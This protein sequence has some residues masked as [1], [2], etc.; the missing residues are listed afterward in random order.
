[1]AKLT[2]ILKKNQLETLETLKDTLL[3]N[4]YKIAGKLYN[5]LKTHCILNNIQMKLDPKGRIKKVLIT[6]K[7]E[8]VLAK[9]IIINNKL[10]FFY[11]KNY[12]NSLDSINIKIEYT[13][14]MK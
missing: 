6:V 11:K 7:G 3:K 5:T 4:D 2:H 10:L 8:K 14:E 1:M 13:C 9:P 12:Y